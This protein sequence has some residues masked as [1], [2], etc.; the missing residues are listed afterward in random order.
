MPESSYLKQDFLLDPQITF[1]NHGSFGATPRPVFETYQNWQR[2]LERQPVEF[3]GRR[4]A[5]LLKTARMA[6]ADYLGT[7]EN[8]L[9]F[10]T[11]TTVGIN[12]IARS[13]D[14]GPGDTILTTNHEYGAMDKTWQFLALRSGFGYRHIPISLPIESPAGFVADLT[15][16]LSRP[17]KAIFISHITSPTAQIFPIKEVIQYAQENG[18]L[19]I[20][21]GAHAPGQLPLNLTDL[22]ADFYVG[23]LH[24]WLC[25][26]K[27]AAFLYAAP[28]VRSL[29]H[30]LTVSWGWEPEDNSPQRLTHYLEW[31]GT[32]DISAFL[33]VP[34]A[35]TYQHQ[36][37]WP[38]VRPTAHHLARETIARIE[39]LTGLPSLYS[40]EHPAFCQMAAARL[41]KATHLE[42]LKT[43]LYDTYRVEVPLIDWEDEKLL[44]ISFQGYNTREDADRLLAALEKELKD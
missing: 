21:D 32:R 26:P 33:S 16:G 19:T 5:E 8:E 2:E 38:T 20:I 39:R 18:I 24:K 27:G 25:A 12:I 29:I 35:I 28:R 9:A 11:N 6:L 30:P 41:P 40:A 37:D 22:G 14:L 10:V 34:A 1:L 36:H 43:T 42:A 23:N 15:A 44:R 31:E 17:P 3:L 13:L 7:A 4:A